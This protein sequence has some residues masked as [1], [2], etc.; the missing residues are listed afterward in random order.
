MIYKFEGHTYTAQAL[1][2]A[3]RWEF[4]DRG[5]TTWD[6]ADLDEMLKHVDEYGIS[7]VTPLRKAKHK[8]ERHTTVVVIPYEAQLKTLWELDVPLENC[9]FN[10]DKLIAFFQ[11][12]LR[13]IKYVID[14]DGTYKAGI[15]TLAKSK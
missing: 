7:E 4:R 12:G 2:R 9:V 1:Q 11:Q 13:I 5:V 8:A 15:Y 10:N 14:R 6:K 3:L